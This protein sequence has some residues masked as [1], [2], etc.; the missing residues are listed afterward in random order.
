LN[1]QEVYPQKEQ[2][3][4]DGIETI[5]Y[6][7]QIKDA[8]ELEISH[9]IDALNVMYMVGY[10]V[11]KVVRAHEPPNVR[12]KLLRGIVNS[13]RSI[14]AREPVDAEICVFFEH[15]KGD[16]LVEK[17]EELGEDAYRE[18]TLYPLLHALP[19][20][21]NFRLKLLRTR[22][23]DKNYRGQFELLKVQDL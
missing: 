20:V 9:V 22:Y 15:R 23:P 18:A 2:P 5:V 11:R 19:I 7:F 4:P 6:R 14:K 1:Y 3:S 12:P 16:F 21:L 17:I 8:S 10:K 13:V